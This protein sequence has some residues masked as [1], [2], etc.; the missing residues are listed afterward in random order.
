MDASL[1][2]RMW[3]VRIQ[4]MD[5]SMGNWI[6]LPMVSSRKNSRNHSCERSQHCCSVSWRIQTTPCYLA[7]PSR[8]WFSTD[9]N[10]WGAACE[11]LAPVWSALSHAARTWAGRGHRAPH[12]RNKTSIGVTHGYGR[13]LDP[14]NSGQSAFSHQQ[15]PSQ[16][17][18]AG[19]RGKCHFE[20]EKL[21][22]EYRLSIL[23]SK[24]RG[25][26]SEASYVPTRCHKWNIPNL[27]SHNGLKSECSP[28]NT[29]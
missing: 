4:G 23:N 12:R 22:Q 24:I 27:V 21:K 3:S 10:T 29:A 16:S 14:L 6:L 9:N 26:K 5:I 25:P 28:K 11:A 13:C 8:K 20:K 2:S 18:L 7:E 17:F 19:W 1:V 15:G